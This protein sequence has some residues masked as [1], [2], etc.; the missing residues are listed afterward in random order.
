MNERDTVEGGNELDSTYGLSDEELTRRFIEAVRIENEIK[1]IKGVPI[2]G[3]DT[4]KKS[5]Y[6]EYPDGSRKYAR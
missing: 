6:L 4:Q 2:C 1:R 5:S 3:Y